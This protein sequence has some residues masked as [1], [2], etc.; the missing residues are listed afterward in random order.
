MIPTNQNH[1]EHFEALPETILNNDLLPSTLKVEEF[2]FETPQALEVFIGNCLEKRTANELYDRFGLWAETINHIYIITESIEEGF[3]IAQI[4]EQERPN[5][6]NP[7]ILERIYI[8]IKNLKEKE[9]LYRLATEYN[10]AVK[11]L[12]LLEKSLNKTTKLEG[13]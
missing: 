5:T 6:L 11:N 2:A 4:L 8:K 1:L 10:I 9:D 13:L 12:K 7:N 3:S